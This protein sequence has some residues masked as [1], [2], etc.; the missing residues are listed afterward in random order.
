MKKE[1]KM[2]LCSNSWNCEITKE[3]KRQKLWYHEVECMI[4]YISNNESV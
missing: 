4:D 3:W 1:M 2:V